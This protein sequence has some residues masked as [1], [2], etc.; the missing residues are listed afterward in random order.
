MLINKDRERFKEKFSFRVVWRMR[1]KAGRPSSGGRKQMKNASTQTNTYVEHM[2][3]PIIIDVKSEIESTDDEAT[4]VVDQEVE[5]FE[6]LK[7]EIDDTQ[8]FSE[9]Q[10]SVPQVEELYVEE[11]INIETL[12]VNLQNENQEKTTE[13]VVAIPEKTAKKRKRS[14]VQKT[15]NGIK[16]KKPKK[17][18]NQNN[19]K[20]QK[21]EKNQKNQKTRKNH[22]KEI[23]KETEERKKRHTKVVESLEPSKIVECSLCKFTCKRPSYLTRHMLTHTG[24]RPHQCIHCPKR[25]AQKTDLNRH[26]ISHAVHYDFHCKS[27][28]RG[29]SDAD[30]QKKHENSCKTK[31]YSCNQCI[32]MTFSIGNMELHM[33]KHTGERPFACDVCDKR[34]TRVSHLNQHVKL[35][36][37]EFDLHCSA[38]GR[39]FSDENDMEK[40][41]ITCKN[42]QF[43]CHMCRDVHHRMDN[44]KRHI[45]ITHMGQKEIMCEYCSKQFPAKSSLA[46]HIQ[47]RHRDRV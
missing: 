20:N 45:K 6:T 36:A 37:E 7:L 41:Q 8:H 34:F 27:C 19:Q 5:I 23:Q 29:F 47:H 42:R 31:R 30:A 4:D 10:R 21:N 38:C 11:K 24:E 33:R 44:L 3:L 32:Y 35:H 43:Q 39:G 28:G 40:H 26:M 25:F 17:P 13:L 16:E 22:K 15:T 2:P 46:K 1:K 14:P 12:Q 9:Y 18:K